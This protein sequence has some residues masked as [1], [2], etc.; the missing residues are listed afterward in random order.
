MKKWLFLLLI[1]LASTSP[2]FAYPP[3]GA[4]CLNPSGSWIPVAMSAIGTIYPGTPPS[5]GIYGSSNGGSAWYPLQ[6]DANGNLS[7]GSILGVTIPALSTGYLY[8]NSGTGLFT[9]AAGGGGGITTNALTAAATGG[10]APGSTFNGAA[11]VT[12]DYHSF[13]AQVN[14]SLIKGTYSD[15]GWCSQTTAGTL[16]N[17]NNAAPQVALPANVTFTVSSS[18]TINANSCS[19]ASGSAGTSVTMTG[20]VSTNALI[21]TPNADITN[22]TGWGNPAAGVLYITVTPGSGAFTYHVCNNT[23]SNITTG[24]SATFNVGA[25]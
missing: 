16:L 10:A 15:G 6:C 1:F 19:P 20:L 14:L 11:A 8:Y 18:T 22:T 25:R 5:T 24:G 2:T 23:A 21:V 4:W 13:G 17:C 7:A 9:W 12:F 3:M